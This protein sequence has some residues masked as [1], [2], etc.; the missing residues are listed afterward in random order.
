MTGC[1]PVGMLSTVF[2][3]L[4]VSYIIDPQPLVCRVLLPLSGIS[5]SVVDSVDRLEYQG[6]MR[7]LLLMC[8]TE[9]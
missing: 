9:S 1:R 7:F 8:W 6:G 2:I 3:F 5:D 4:H